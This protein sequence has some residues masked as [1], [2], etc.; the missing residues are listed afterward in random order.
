MSEGQRRHNSTRTH[1]T[2]SSH[3][4]PVPKV[5][6]TFYSCEPST[7]WHTKM[8]PICDPINQIL[9]TF[10]S[11]NIIFSPCVLLHWPL[12]GSTGTQRNTG[13]W[14]RPP[15]LKTLRCSKRQII[16]FQLVS[17]HQ[18]NLNQP[19]FKTHQLTLSNLPPYTSYSPTNAKGKRLPFPR[20]KTGSNLLFVLPP[21]YSGC[22]CWSYC[23]WFNFILKALWSS[24]NYL[25]NTWTLNLS[26]WSLK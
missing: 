23:P 17:C 19:I 5:S 3:A 14:N 26:I 1:Q 11:L 7:Q 18:K 12:L 9:T 6:T 20:G 10:T 2:T 4:Q 22:I 13:C 15:H 25:P 16:S 21:P 8:S 24:L